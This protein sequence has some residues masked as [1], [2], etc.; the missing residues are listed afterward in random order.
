MFNVT[1]LSDF[2]WSESE[3]TSSI[4]TL[5]TP[6]VV[7]S[8]PPNF[9]NIKTTTAAKNWLDEMVSQSHLFTVCLRDTKTIIG[10]VFLSEWDNQ[11]V[12]L[13]YLLGEL[14]WQQGY[15]SEFLSGFITDCRDNH[16][17]KSLIGG[18]EAANV[19]SAKLL[20]KLGFEQSH[21]T[22]NGVTFYQRQLY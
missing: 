11:N 7:K 13:G 20:L 2:A 1:E 9:Q 14:F 16:L 10:F 19:P 5:L 22:E 4:L 21:T 18:V 15:A 6:N 12:H 8:L 3:L 17:V